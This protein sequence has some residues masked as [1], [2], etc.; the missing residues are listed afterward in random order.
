MI[1][2]EINDYI[3]KSY[4]RLMEYA[5]FHAKQAG[6]E[7][8]A[9]DLLNEVLEAV[10]EKEEPFLLNLLT[11]KK[12]GYTGFDFYILNLIK[13]NATSKTSPFRYK[14]E[15][16]K[17][18]ANADYRKLIIYDS[19][20]DEF[21]NAEQLRKTKLIEEVALEVIET[22]TDLELFTRRFYNREDFKSMEKPLNMKWRK[23][24]L[25]YNHILK[26]IS[27]LIE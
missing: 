3:N 24:N 27:Q 5:I 21:K 26:N 23:L 12:Q 7:H 22:D 25:R 11:Q 18:D 17:I 10:L 16:Q 4:N 13:R 9:G 6:F 19:P 14:E 20:I 1:H 2:N 15:K 8:L